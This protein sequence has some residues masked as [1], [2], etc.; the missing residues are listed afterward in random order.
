MIRTI[1]QFSGMR[2]DAIVNS[3]IVFTTKQCEHDTLN[4]RNPVPNFS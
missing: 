4:G 1:T 2:T 3:M